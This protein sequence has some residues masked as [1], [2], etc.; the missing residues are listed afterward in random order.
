M[1]SLH[2]LAARKSR[3]GR[4]YPGSHP[5]VDTFV[6]VGSVYVLHENSHSEMVQSQREMAQGLVV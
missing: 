4:H 3:C 1:H 5:V 6:P 2:R